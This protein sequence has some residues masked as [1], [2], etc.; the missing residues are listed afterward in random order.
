MNESRKPM[1]ITDIESSMSFPSKIILKELIYNLALENLIEVI[2]SK[3]GEYY[4]I[5]PKGRMKTYSQ[6]LVTFR[7]C[8]SQIP[9]EPENFTAFEYLENFRER[10]CEINIYA[11]ELNAYIKS[12]E[13]E[14]APYLSSFIKRGE[15]ILN[16]IVNNLTDYLN[17]IEEIE[18]PNSTI[19][20]EVRAERKWM[21]GCSEA[22]SAL[23]KAVNQ[24]IS[25]SHSEGHLFPGVSVST[26]YP[27]ISNAVDNL[28]EYLTQLFFP[29][30][31]TQKDKKEDIDSEAYSI[32]IFPITIFGDSPEYEISIFRLPKKKA[33]SFLVN[34][35][36]TDMYRFR[37]WTSLGH[38]I[39]HVKLLHTIQSSEH[40]ETFSPIFIYPKEGQEMYDKIMKNFLYAIGVAYQKSKTPENKYDKLKEDYMFLSFISQQAEEVLADIAS[41]CIFGLPSLCTLICWTSDP[42]EGLDHMTDHPPL[43]V[44][45]Y[46][47]LKFLDSLKP[48]T[49]SYIR[50]LDDLKR[51][52]GSMENS[53]KDLNEHQEFIESYK[54]AVD[55]NFSL[56]VDFTT[57][58]LIPRGKIF[59]PELWD[60]NVLA[61]DM[62]NSSLKKVP[63]NETPIM[64]IIR[65][66][67][68]RWVTYA[69]LSE[70]GQSDFS[71][72]CK[73]HRTET[74]VFGQTINELNWM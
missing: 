48:K 26:C 73:W 22:L 61:Q 53:I 11:Q 1:T 64:C 69:H 17:Q 42:N 8:S 2:T 12:V 41:L 7:M 27:R 19:F 38:E 21:D 55:D 57:K 40:D 20:D 10:L 13:K 25:I 60:Q 58:Y 67:A 16:V 43:S 23:E 56:L 5:S 31:S 3:S 47:M 34:V 39:A 44:R 62:V 32:T 18:T 65:A 74:K 37:F 24:R 70:S 28:V 29:P 36:R 15:T 6:T 68:K 9:H 50:A 52:W 72:F 51:N 63:N 49:E 66:W 46:Y 71:K 54:K 33:L 35:P 45:I 4:T 30:L 14:T 59:T